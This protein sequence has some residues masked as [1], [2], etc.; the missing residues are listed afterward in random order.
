MSRFLATLCISGLVAIGLAVPQ[1]VLA[2]PIT[3]YELIQDVTGTCTEAVETGA[4]TDLVQ[5]LQRLR[6]IT[7]PVAGP[8]LTENVDAVIKLATEN[9]VDDDFGKFN[10]AQVTYAHNVSW[11]IPVPASY[12]SATLTIVAYNVRGSNDNV[13]FDTID[14]SHLL[15]ALA[16]DTNDVESTVF[17]GTASLLASLTDGMLHIFINKFPT[18]A[19]SSSDSINILSSRLE[20]TYEPVVAS[21]PEPTTFALIGAGLLAA[22]SRRRR[23]RR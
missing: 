6:Q 20:V 4:C 17:G 14:A 8:V 21:I 2:A 9:A 23:P 11:L 7:S 16:N 5:D 15:G 3:A 19:A 13:Y 12:V 18:G 1:P 22:A 10:A